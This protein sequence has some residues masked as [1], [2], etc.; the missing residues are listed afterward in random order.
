M[1]YGGVRVHAPP[2]KK[3]PQAQNTLV[4]G[5]SRVYRVCRRVPHRVRV[6]VFCF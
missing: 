4:C 3:K 1:L 5:H 6:G 2:K